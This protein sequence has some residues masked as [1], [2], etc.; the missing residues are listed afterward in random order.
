MN[1]VSQDGNTITINESS[2]GDVITLRAEVLESEGSENVIYTYSAQTSTYVNGTPGVGIT[3]I[4]SGENGSI[5]IT[6]SDGDT[7]AFNIPTRNSITLYYRGDAVN[8]NKPTLYG[9]IWED[10]QWA[11]DSADN[12]DG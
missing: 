2:G 5:D 12:F 9:V 1:G 11:I 10:N 4:T 8:A 7:K 6:T 3:A